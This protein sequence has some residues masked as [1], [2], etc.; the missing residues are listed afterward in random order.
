MWKVLF[1]IV[2][3]FYGP[4]PSHCQEIIPIDARISP[5]TTFTPILV[6]DIKL[7]F[8][9]AGYGV[10]IPSNYPV[11][12]K[13]SLEN[14]EI[15]PF[16]EIARMEMTGQRVQ[17]KKFVQPGERS[18]Y[19]SIDEQGYYHWSEIEVDVRLRDWDGE[20]TKARLKRPELCDVYLIGRT[21]RG[22]YELQIDQEN[23]KT[24]VVE[25]LANFIMQCTENP[26]HIFPNKEYKY[27]PLCGNPLKRVQRP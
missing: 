11:V 23:D 6:K 22:E 17:W 5:D 24:I 13:I 18:E 27:C 16:P 12:T 10:Y 1:V 19:P 20:I 2:F 14:G 8:R 9:F 26:T 21:E 15:I 3:L 7:D 4:E 25:F